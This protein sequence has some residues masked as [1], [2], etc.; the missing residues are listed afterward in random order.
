M[1]TLSRDIAASLLLALLDKSDCCLE[2]SLSGDIVEKL[3]N[4]EATGIAGF[5]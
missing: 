2:R 4:C 1:Q 5:F 3:R